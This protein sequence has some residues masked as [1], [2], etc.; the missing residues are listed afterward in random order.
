MI[1]V[2]DK[3]AQDEKGLGKYW[4]EN[5]PRGDPLNRNNLSGGD[6]SFAELPDAPPQPWL[7]RVPGVPND[8]TNWF[9]KSLAG[10]DIKEG[11]LK[12][13][14]L[15]QE[16]RFAVYTPPG[17]DTKN[18][19][20]PVLVMFDGNGCRVVKDNPFPV[21]LILDNLIQQKAI[22][23]L[24]TV[25]VFQTEKR[26]KELSCS[27]TFADFISDE[28]LPQVR[29]E[30]RVTSDASR[31]IVCGMSLGGLM[32]SYCAYRHPDVFGNVLS[33]SGSYQWF[34]GAFDGVAFQDAE[35]GWLTREFV[36]APPKEV[37]FYL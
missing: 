1:N 2:P 16:R 12:S 33:L 27:E 23:P 8:V 4:K 26:N 13:K 34:P 36:A 11:T 10:R 20:Y 19:P 5:P 14:I 17:Y 3:I 37:R 24:I 7:Q 15:D 6:A 35:P 22:P 28:L 30:Y 18:E 29:R 9:E 25:F 31:T 21:A 32:S